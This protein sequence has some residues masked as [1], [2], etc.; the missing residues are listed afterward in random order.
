VI[1]DFEND[2]ARRARDAKRNLDYRMLFEV[3][4]ETIGV[5]TDIRAITRKDCED[6]RNLLLRLPPHSRKSFPALRFADIADKAD[7]LGIER[8]LTPQTV[9]S[10][11][12]KLSTFFN[13]AL[14]RELVDRNPARNLK[15]RGVGH[16][17]TDRDPYSPN[18][19]RL[20]FEGPLFRETPADKR[21]ERFWL[22][23]F[24]LHQGARANELAQLLVADIR[25][26]GDLMGFAITPS[27]T[28]KR[29]K[30]AASKRIIPVHPTMLRLGF[31]DYVARI[32]REGHDRLW[33]NL[34]PCPRGYYS[35]YFVRWFARYLEKR[36]V[37]KRGSLRDGDAFH[38]FR[39]CWAD[40][41]READIPINIQEA[42][43]GWTQSTVHSKYGAGY[44]LRRLTDEI[45]KIDFPGLNLPST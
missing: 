45:G 8:R 37:K 27:G 30:T 31:R 36:G 18:E 35:T 33:P 40:A 6:V 43:G 25:E 32:R 11:L 9:N 39:H 3:V 16:A 17:I 19:L 1:A 34:R 12:A 5:R 38:P 13:W 2:P 42:I 4:R 23:L 29:I 41:A 10:H 21:N 14:E 24:A 7:A 15:I 26:E 28:G 44:S 22:P 20:I